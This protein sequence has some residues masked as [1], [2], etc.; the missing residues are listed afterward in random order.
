MAQFDAGKWLA[1][2][3]LKPDEKLAIMR[4]IMA[5]EAVLE[6][7]HTPVM[8]GGIRPV[9]EFI[10]AA[11]ARRELLEAGGIA[12]LSSG[13][14]VV[15]QLTKGLAPGELILVS[16]RTS[17]GKSQLAVNVAFRVAARGVGVLFVTLEMTGAEVTERL[18]ACAGTEELE[19]LPVFIQ[20]KA[21]LR[22]E[23]F[24]A[25]VRD[26]LAE[27][28]IGLVVLDHVHMWIRGENATGK[29]G[30]VS[31]MVKRVAL[32]NEVP[33]MALAQL[34]K[35]NGEEVTIEDVKDSAVLAQDADVVLMVNRPAMDDPEGVCDE[36]EVRVKAEKNRNRGLDMSR[37]SGRLRA[38]GAVL[39]D[40]SENR[41]G[42]AFPGRRQT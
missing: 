31:A 16:G 1:A 22:E 18:M 27:N 13:F 8:G 23:E 3:R 38:S 32:A 35:T 37:R 17:H 6:L 30:L 5:D 36:S 4:Q 33:V 7:A 42:S 25:L 15:D 28:E 9:S 39:E 34:R 29:A 26:S 21:D 41:A 11:R 20:A 14:V 12:G 10:A 40:L 19:G 24:E 2:K